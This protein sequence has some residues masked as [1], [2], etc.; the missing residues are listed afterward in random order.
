MAKCYQFSTEQTRLWNEGDGW[1]T[2]RLE[3]DVLD[4]TMQF[5]IREPVVVVTSDHKIAFALTAQ[6][7]RA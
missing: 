5:N 6:G 2:W 4:W 3:E 7:V 1:T